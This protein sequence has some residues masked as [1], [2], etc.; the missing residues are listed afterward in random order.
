M[1]EEIVWCVI[2]NEYLREWYVFFMF[3]YRSVIVRYLFGCIVVR[4]V[5]MGGGCFFG[6]VGIFFLIEMKNVFLSYGK[7]FC[8]RR[9]FLF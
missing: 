2:L 8:K 1:I 5:L 7:S 6:L 4:I 9:Y 3:K